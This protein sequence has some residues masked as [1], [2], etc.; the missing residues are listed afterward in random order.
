MSVSLSPRKE[1]TK[2]PFHNLLLPLVAI[3]SP[4]SLSGGRGSDIVD[5]EAVSV[6]DFVRIDISGT[7]ERS[8]EIEILI[9]GKDVILALQKRES[10]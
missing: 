9:A 4:T 1:F 7:F 8:G 5:K 10:K 3:L 6:D 2:I